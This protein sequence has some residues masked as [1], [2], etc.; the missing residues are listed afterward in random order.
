M[1]QWKPIESAP[2]DNKRLLYL[3]RFDDDGQLQE[4]DF[5]GVWEFWQENWEMPHING[6]A[7]FSANGIQEPTHW[8]Y[9]DLGAPPF[10]RGDTNDTQAV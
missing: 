7:W 10:V 8:A 3:A 1:N 5:D 4:L 2:K 6:Y 9:Q